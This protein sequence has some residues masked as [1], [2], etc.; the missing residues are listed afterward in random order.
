M[1]HHRMTKG[2]V[3][4][5]QHPS[6]MVIGPG[7]VDYMCWE[8]KGYCPFIK[9]IFFEW[10]L[11]LAISLIDRI[12]LFLCVCTGQSVEVISLGYSGGAGNIQLIEQLF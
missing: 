11:Y 8:F 5:N 6:I 9:L 1:A 7:L 2:V 4:A 3:A 12:I 10:P